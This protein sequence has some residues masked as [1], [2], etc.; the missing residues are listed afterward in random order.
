MNELLY[1]LIGILLGG[2]SIWV[3]RTRQWQ[4]QQ[5]KDMESE[6]QLRT[7]LSELR[8]AL[9][10]MK[11]A[12]SVAKVEFTELN[13]RFLDSSRLAAS[14]QER[15]ELLQK[16]NAELASEQELHVRT[17]QEVRE[18]LTT[19]RTNNEHLRERLEVQKTDLVNLEER[20]R[21]EFQVLASKILDEKSLKFTEQNQQ[22]ITQILN[23]LGE[24]LQEFS[25][26]VRESYE[27][28]MRERVSLQVQIKSLAELNLKMSEDA[29]NLTR[30]LKGD[31]K[32]QGNWGE[33]ILERILE[34]SG[35]Q[36]DREYRIQ[37]SHTTEDNRRL[38][39]DV[40]IDLPDSKHLIIDSKVSITAYERYTSANNENE[41]EIARKEHVLSI[42][43]HVKSLSEKKYQSL[44]E[45][46]SPD[47][48]LMFVPVEPAF[49]LAI[50]SA[51]ELYN[52]AFEKNIVMVSPSTLLATLFTI[53]SIWKQEYRSRNAVEIARQGGDLYDKFVGF[54]DDMDNLGKSLAK[55]TEQHQ[56]ALNKLSTGRG[57][58][59]NRA[60]K[61]RKLGISV[62]KQL[63]NSFIDP[64]IDDE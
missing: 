3:I 36:R 11:N 30:A 21:N 15:A 10:E 29:T 51:P 39:P 48:V 50:Q 1:M 18:E 23:P 6:Q 58:L 24:K 9:S 37:A 40:I 16:R 28:E 46:N 60:E 2:L 49:A 25:R 61:L 5:G 44:Y 54:L 42:R 4:S 45:I 57:N 8:A 7:E 32:A 27:T 14:S 56:N 17:L 34:R 22:N 55:T 43:S 47:F 53:A 12:G 63:P 38:Q 19:L 33:V 62:S 26:Q 41:Q 31:S 52:D 13:N 20:F 64:Q 59:V 35:L